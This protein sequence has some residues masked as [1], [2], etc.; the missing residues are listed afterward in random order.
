MECDQDTKNKNTTV[1]HV[2]WLP[3]KL[4]HRLS[5]PTPQKGSE[6]EKR[7]RTAARLSRDLPWFQ[8]FDNTATRGPDC[9]ATAVTS[10]E[11]SSRYLRPQIVFYNEWDIFWE[12][13]TLI[14]LKLLVS[15]FLKETFS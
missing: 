14:Q 1:K 6:H 4:R 15:N 10:V 2:P 7:M 9:W 8:S 13:I 3:M 5:P 12:G 11:H